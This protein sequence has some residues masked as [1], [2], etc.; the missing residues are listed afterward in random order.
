MCAMKR[1]ERKNISTT[2]I[3]PSIIAFPYILAGILGILCFVNVFLFS[4]AAP[5]LRFTV[6][7]NVSDKVPMNIVPRAACV[8]NKWLLRLPRKSLPQGPLC[9]KTEYVT[10]VAAAS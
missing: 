1:C 4:P 2:K 10:V 3:H 6:C 8:P 7:D 5:W 9:F